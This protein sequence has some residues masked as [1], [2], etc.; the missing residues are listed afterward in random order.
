MV[1]PAPVPAMKCSG[2]L[3]FLSSRVC[4]SYTNLPEY[5]TSNRA[6]TIHPDCENLTTS[7]EIPYLNGS[8]EP[9][10]FRFPSE[11]SSLIHPGV[12][13]RDFMKNQSPYPYILNRVCL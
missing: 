4:D 8:A 13:M 5:L 3:F 12:M 11:I 1:S 10:P 9:L 6:G 7:L 2:V